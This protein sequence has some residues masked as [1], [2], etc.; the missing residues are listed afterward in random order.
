LTVKVPVNGPVF[1]MAVGVALVG[2]DVDAVLELSCLARVTTATTATRA[3]TITAAAMPAQ[4][5]LAFEPPV[6]AAGGGAPGPS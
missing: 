5:S 6:F 3:T 2:V 4:M 1:G